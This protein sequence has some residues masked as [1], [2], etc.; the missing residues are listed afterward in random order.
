[1]GYVASNR[2]ADVDIIKDH[3]A[4]LSPKVQQSEMVSKVAEQA[5]AVSEGNR[6]VSSL[7]RSYKVEAGDTFQKISR[8]FFDTSKRWGEIHNLNINKI[9][10]PENLK[11]GMTILIPE[12]AIAK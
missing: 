9:P 4:K 11:S 8:K 3:L 1:M 6:K 5:T 10:H 12:G 7:G 2:L